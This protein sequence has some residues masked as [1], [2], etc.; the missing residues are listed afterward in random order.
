MQYCV[1]FKLS[2]LS[3]AAVHEKK[4]ISQIREHFNETPY[5]CIFFYKLCSVLLSTTDFFYKGPKISMYIQGLDSADPA[6]D[7]F[8]HFH[9]IFQRQGLSIIFYIIF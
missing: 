7:L 3:V 5:H 6:A 2:P 4:E 1:R 9:F 8:L